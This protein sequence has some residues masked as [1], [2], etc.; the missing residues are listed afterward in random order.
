M[1]KTENNSYIG[2]FDSGV[3][4]LTLLPALESLLPNENFLYISDDA[5]APYG[6]KDKNEIINRCKIVTQNLINK[7]CKLI[8][9]ACNTAT[10]NAIDILRNDFPIPFIGIEPAIKPA[11]LESKTKVIGVLATKGTLSSSLFAK[12]SATITKDV[13]VIEQVGEGLVE[14]IETGSLNSPDLT[15]LLE[16]YINP[17]LDQNIDTLV[18]G[19]TH[20]PFLISRLKN[21]LPE[22]VKIIDSADAV[23]K[24]TLKVLLNNNLE[25]LNTEKG[26]VEFISSS[27]KSS[28]YNFLP[29]ETLVTVLNSDFS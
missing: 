29:N 25:C 21:M 20:Y 27:K 28:L 6:K 9:V 17:M 3:G 8:I 11:A 14:L 15:K 10:T 22:N 4:G 12:T 24:Q 13:Q 18:L 16:S 26:S 23:A 19:C 5:F 2:I 7:G 1:M